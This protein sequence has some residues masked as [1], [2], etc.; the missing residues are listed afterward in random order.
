MLAVPLSLWKLLRALG[1]FKAK[2]FIFSDH[3][4]HW[5]FLGILWGVGVDLVWDEQGPTLLPHAPS[6]N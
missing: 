2:L 6:G 3:N 1:S 5:L 4:E